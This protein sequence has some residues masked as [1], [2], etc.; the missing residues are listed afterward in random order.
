MIYAFIAVAVGAALVTSFAEYLF[1]KIVDFFRS[2]DEKILAEKNK[3]EKAEAKFKA[4]LVSKFPAIR[5][6]L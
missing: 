4:K 6:K 5:R 1:D 3:L 2:E